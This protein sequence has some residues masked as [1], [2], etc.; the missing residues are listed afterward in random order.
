MPL[1][2]VAG[3]RLALGGR[4]VLDGVSFTMS[5]GEVVGLLGP[6][7]AGKTTTLSVLSTLRRPDAGTAIVAGH[8]I[9][10]APADV[11]RALGVVPQ[12]VALY[13]SFTARENLAFFARMLGL[14]GARAVSAIAQALELVG[15]ADRA[16]DVVATFSGGMQRRLN[17]GCGLLH[18]PRV[19]CLDEPTVG[20]DP[21]SRE[22]ILDAVRGQAERGAAVLYSTHYLEEA[23]RVCDRVVLLDHGR[24]IAAGTP[25]ALV[26]SGDDGLQLRLVTRRALPDGWLDGLDVGRVVAPPAAGTRGHETHIVLHTSALASRVLERAATAGDGVLEFHLHAPSLQDVFLQLTGKDLRD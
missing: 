18:D 10:T 6:N 25:G 11:R 15:L 19:L 20:V 13:P 26:G 22:R 12:S 21:Q 16:D 3:L 8:P 17:L 9:A 24:V 23:E 7:G 4:T 1:V 14:G 5:A 2:E